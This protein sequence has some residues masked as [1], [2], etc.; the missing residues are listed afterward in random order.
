MYGQLIWHGYAINMTRWRGSVIFFFF[1]FFYQIC[2]E[3]YK[4]VTILK[5]FT[6]FISAFKP[7]AHGWTSAKDCALN[8]WVRN[9]N[10]SI[11]PAVW[12]QPCCRRP[13]H[14]EGQN[15]WQQPGPARCYDRH[16]HR[17]LPAPLSGPHGTW[18]TYA[19]HMKLGW[20]VEKDLS[21]PY[22]W[23]NK[24]FNRVSETKKM[25]ITALSD[26]PPL[27]FSSTRQSDDVEEL[28]PLK[29]P[30]WTRPHNVNKPGG[31]VALAA[32]QS[33]AISIFYLSYCWNMCI[34]HN[35]CYVLQ[36]I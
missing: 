23:F 16:H 6:S 32:C 20:H 17:F 4:I 5:S 22:M 27:S 13:G 11:R 25:N 12:H 2:N 26:I 21:F 10:I 19:K 1:F 31:R 24:A 36:W 15:V 35:C 14:P 3:S 7:E 18:K 30:E 9:L 33:R 8:F 34:M 29:R 28:D